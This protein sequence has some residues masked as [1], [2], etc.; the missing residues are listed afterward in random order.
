ML[1]GAKD[2]HIHMLGV[3]INIF[4]AF[5]VSHALLT[6]LG[7]VEAVLWRYLLYLRR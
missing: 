7:G 5:V 1:G 2:C 3:R 4:H 6:P